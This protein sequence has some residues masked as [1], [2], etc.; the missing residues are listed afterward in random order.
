LQ[1]EHE[2][3]WLCVPLPVEYRNASVSI[4]D[5]R[6]E[7]APERFARA[8]VDKEAAPVRHGLEAAVEGRKKSPALP[9]RDFA[10]SSR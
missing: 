8:T 3:A 7:P 4:L 2:Q 6:S 10:Q 9:V 1:R 5:E